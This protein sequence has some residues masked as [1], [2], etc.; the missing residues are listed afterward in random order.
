MQV[1]MIPGAIVLGAILISVILWL[2][3]GKTVR[4]FQRVID[5]KAGITATNELLQQEIMKK[6]D[7]LQKERGINLELSKENTR[8]SAEYRN[9]EEKMSVQRQEIEELQ[10]KFSDA[11]ENLANRIFEEKAHK[12]TEKNRANIDEILNPLKEKIKEFEFK[13][14]DT[15]KKNLVSNAALIEQ[16]RNLEKLNRQ[17]SDDAEN[18]TRALKGDI[19]IHGNWGEV[20]LKR[21]LEESGLRE[22]IEYISQG[23]GMGLKS[24]AGQP[25]KPDIIV[26]LPDD[27]H[28]IIDSKVSLVAYERLVQAEDE[29]QKERY[30]KELERSIKSHIDGLYS[31]HYQKVQGLNSPDFVFLFMPIEA[32]F[33]IALHPDSSL[34][35]EA[36]DKKIII[37]GPS[38][39]LATLR[40]IESIWKQENQTRNALEIA[41]Q[42]GN[43]YDAFMRLLEDLDQ[44]GVNL[45]RAKASY[46]DAVKKIKTGRGNLVNRVQNL[47][48]LGASTSKSLPGKFAPD[49]LEQLED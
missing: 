39:L 15:H 43:L 6:E 32:S 25:T 4:E 10:K 23:R 41:R 26:K 48:K 36:L 14:E 37:V 8:L 49:S 38:G 7:D 1:Y 9:L 46:D 44:V 33:T 34:F 13:V 2:L 27:R 20:I 45:D 18:L 16:I 3:R 28:I 47:K 35:K 29:V 30:R 5:E 40:T 17:I 42:S 21:L 11:F 12:F 24:E 31:R 19:K 22:G